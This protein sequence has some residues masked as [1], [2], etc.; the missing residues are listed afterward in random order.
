MLAACIYGVLAGNLI[1]LRS[2][3]KR[4]NKSWAQDHAIINKS[5]PWSDCL[6]ITDA[7]NCLLWK[8]TTYHSIDR[9]SS[10][11]RKGDRF[12]AASKRVRDLTVPR[13]DDVWS[14]LARIMLTLPFKH[15]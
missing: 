2:N 8:E 15:R 9:S 11:P 6:K 13:R 4:G 10:P 14:S 12:L 1:L 3:E 5:S 7:S